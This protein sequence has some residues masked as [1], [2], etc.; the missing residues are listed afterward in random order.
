[1]EGKNG[2]IFV[3]AI[4]TSKFTNDKYYLEKSSN[5]GKEKDD[6]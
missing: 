1:M 5:H 6:I 4:V 2:H 3:C